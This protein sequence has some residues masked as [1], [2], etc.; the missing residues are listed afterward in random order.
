M[1]EQHEAGETVAE[2]AERLERKVRITVTAAQ[3]GEGRGYCPECGE[4]IGN[5]HAQ[6][7][8]SLERPAWVGTGQAYARPGWAR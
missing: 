1:T 8:A 7:C 2:Y 5:Y 6:S 3:A 4:L